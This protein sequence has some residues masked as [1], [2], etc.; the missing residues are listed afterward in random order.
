MQIVLSGKRRF[1][2]VYDLEA[3]AMQRITLHGF[4]GQRT[5][6]R[7]EVSPDQHTLAFLGAEGTVILV[8]AKACTTRD[9]RL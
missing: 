9:V 2:F 1:F 8:S 4:E 5:L 6:E 7:F 3:G